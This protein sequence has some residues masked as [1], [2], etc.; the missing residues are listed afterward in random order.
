[1]TIRQPT[2]RYRQAMLLE[3]RM[4]FD[5]AAV[6]TAADV[7][8]TVAATDTA[9]GVDATPVQ[10]A[11]AITDSSDSFPAVDLFSGVTVTSDSSGQNL[12]ELVVTVN[13]SGANQ[14]LIIDGAEIKLQSGE[15]STD[16][17]YSYQVTVSGDAATIT[18]S[19]ESALEGGTPQATAA[20]IDS[21]AYQ[22]LDNTVESGAVTVTLKTLSDASDSAALDISSTV[23]IDSRV[24]VAPV[25][26]DD[27]ALEPAESFTIDDLGDNVT[28]VYAGGGDY[29]YAAGDGALSVF[30]VDDG[31]RLTLVGTS[32]VEGLGSV[33]DM[34]IGA[35]D[36]SLYLVNGGNGDVYAVS[37]AED[38]SLGAVSTVSAGDTTRNIALSSDGAYV[39]VTLQN[40]GMAVFARDGDSGALSLIQTVSEGDLGVSR[41]E[42]V[43]SANGYL[44]VIGDR[45]SFV[46][47]TDTLSVL[48]I[49]DDGTLTRIDSV[50]A[51]AVRSSSSTYLM[52]VSEDAAFLYL[53]SSA[54][55]SIQ[56]YRFSD[57]A[58]TLQSTLSLDGIS[59]IALSRDGGLLYAA[60]TGGAIG[61]YAVGGDGALTPVSSIAGGSA[62]DIAVSGDGLSVLV[63]GGGGVSRYSAAQT[64]DRGAY[65]TF[66]DG[67]TLADGN[68]DALNDGAGNYNG[69]GITVSANVAGG[70]FGFADGGGLTY[71]DG[72]ISLDG[73][74]IATLSVSDDGALTVKFTA[75]A[76]TAIANQVLQ[77]LTYANDGAAVGSYILLTVAASDGALASNSV[78]TTLRVNAVPQVN[79]DASTGYVLSAATSETDYSFTLFPGLFNDADGDSLIWSVSG[80]PQGL[81]F[82]AATRTI[83]GSATEAGDF[84]V[85][86]T[87]SDASGASA[88][89]DLDLTV[90]QIANR[91]P[92]VN[93]EVSSALA[94]ATENA[95]YSVTLDTSLFSDADSLYGDSLNWT[96]EGLPTGL[97]F[98]AATLTISGTAGAVG[99]YTVTVT[100]TDESGASASAE[101]T[102]RVI[103][104]DEA[105]NSAPVLDAPDSALAYTID[106]NLTGFNQYVYGLQLS[107]DDGT[108]IV[109]GN[110]SNS[111]AITPSGNSTL[112][113]YSRDTETGA[114]T[115]V[116]TFVQGAGDDGD[117]ANGIE[118]NGLDSATSSIYSADGQYVYLVGKDASGAYAI[119]VLSVNDDGTLS[120]TGLSAEVA[121]ASQIKQMVMSS[122][123]DSLYVVSASTL[124]AYRVEENG[125]LTLA[126]AYSDSY[127]TA[128]A[129]AVDSSGNVYVLGGSRLVVY[130]ANDDGSL[131]Y[132]TTGT[133]IGL[134]AT[135]RG[136]VV[137]DAGYIYVATGSGGTVVTLHYDSDSNAVTRVASVSAAQVWGL[138]LSADG[139]AL[140]VGYLTGAVYVYSV[141]DD[142]SL[143]RTDSLTNSGGRAFR[144]AISSDGSSI[145]VGGFY[146]GTGLGQISTGAVAVAYTEGGIVNPAA[147][148]TLS[149][150]DNDALNG[151][152]GNYNGAAFTL[153]RAGGANAADSYGFT[154]G[155]GLTLAD[156]IISLNGAAI[157]TF[158]S[159]DGALTVK[160][161]AD[162]ATAVANQVLQ[163]IAYSNGSA[164]PGGSITL[165][166]SVADQYRSGSL[167]LRLAVTEINDAPT[168][169][170]S[171][172]SVVYTSGGNAVKLF[173]DSAV[174]TVEEGQT[175]SSLT[176]TVS[177]LTDGESETL[178]VGGVSVA[179]T[180]GASAGGTITLNNEDGGTADYGYT[181]SVSVIDGV[182]TVTLSGSLPTEAADALIDSIAYAN[183]SDSP[184]IGER[185]ITLTSIQDNG[186]TD[187]GGVNTSELA[188]ASTVAVALTNAA[189][190]VSATP[191]VA[192]YVENA[193]AA[194]LF[195][196][197]VL[198]TGEAGQAIS[199]IVLTVSG[200][201]DGASEALVI[202]GTAVSLTADAAGETANGYS[203]SVTL[204]GTT[205]T[206]TISGSDGIAVQDATAL[207]AGLGYANQSDDPTAG[208]RTVT[209]AAVQDDGGTANG[210]S[211]SVTP[212]IAASVA[213]VAVN[214]APLVS[215]TPA[216]AIYSTSGSSAG[217][218]SDVSLSTVENDQTLSAIT[219]TVAG[220]ADGDSET[221]TVAGSRIA[222]VDGSGTL[223]NGYAYT[224]TLDGDTAVVT[225]ASDAGIAA[226]AA[227]ALIEQSS[228][229]NL[230]NTQTAGVRTF[231]LS[232]Q[233]SGGRDNGGSDTALLE[234]AAA[235]E[236]V[237]NSAPEF[238][239]G[240][241]YTNL[242]VA[243]SLTAVSGLNDITASALTAGGDYLYVAGSDG[244]IAIFSRNTATGEL[245]LL[246]T[247]DSGVSSVSLIEVSEDGGTLYLLG[248]GGD[249]ITIFSR[250]GGD[251][252]LTQV[253][254]LT[255]ENVVDLTISAD[256][257]ALYVVDGNYS[258]LLV[259]T[260][261]AESGQYALRQSISAATG[262][263][264]YLFTAIGVE[265][266]GDYVYVATDPAAET[267]ANTL[268][269]YQRAADGTLSAV[270]WLRDGAAAGESAI[271]MSGPVDIAVSRD[272][273]T[274]YVA[275]EDGVAVFGFDAA[276]GTL[277]YDGALG[278]LSGVTAVALSGDDGTLYVTS[279][280][281]SISRY[282]SDGSLTL[283]ET[284][285]SSSTAALAGARSV[286]TG[287][288][289]AVVVI[290]SGGVVSLKDGLTAITVDY[291]EQETIRPLNAITL[292]DADYDALADGAGNYN[293]AVITLA[294][295]GGASGDDG[296]SFVD[297][298]GLTLADGTIYLDGA[299]I[300]AFADVEGTL[301]LT[302]T[303]DVT[304]ASANR[305]LQQIGYSNASDDPGANLSLVLRVT[306]AYGAGAGVTLSLNVTEVNDAPL[307]TTT[308]ADAGYVEGGEAA[309][310][311]S[312]TAV[313]TVEAGQRVNALTL[314]V[315]GLSDGAGETLTID[316]T[317]IALIAGSGTTAGGYAYSVSLSDGVATVAIAGEAGISAAAAAALVDGIAY[318]NVSDDP[319]VGTR[320]I[321]LSA[322]QD[323]GG[324]ADGGV[325]ATTLAVTAAVTVTAVNDAPTL[326]V[327][328]INANYAA[329]DDALPLFNGAEVAAVE[330]GQSIAALTVTV[331]GVADNAERLI[332][333]GASVTLTDG[334]VTTASGLTVTV[335]L[336]NGTATLV[337]TRAD[338]LSS[339]G[340]AALI[341]GLAYANDSAV[342]TA[343]ER[344]I[345][346][347]AVQDDG[348]TANGGA[349]TAVLN[350]AATVNIVNSAPQATDAEAELPA[351]TQAAAY[352]ATL[353]GDLF[354]DV[355]GDALS[356]RVDGLPEG[357]V[358]DA[359]T[360][361]IS[362]RTLAVGSFELTITVS[363]GQ[364]GTA[365]RS[366]TLTV[367]KQ[368]VSPVFL[369]ASNASDM[370]ERLS[371]QEEKRREEAQNAS[372]RPTAPPATVQ[373]GDSLAREHYPL[374]NGA[375]D[376]A[377]TPWLLNP[378]LA[379]LMP[380]LEKVDF[381]PQERAAAGAPARENHQPDPQAVRTDIPAG[382]AAFS[383]QLQQDRA[384]YDD[385]LSAL[386][387]LTANG[388]SP[389]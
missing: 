78:V 334:A 7:A 354:S 328:P 365:S 183:A 77:Q 85:T 158:A 367:D 243:A 299:A 380:P 28:V 159:A 195:S 278:D 189:P 307:L 283:V 314:S 56:V 54:D 46:A 96:V 251:G 258:G 235:I 30:A 369:P 84:T 38:G 143:T 237:N 23:T 228:Y 133:G 125:A 261:D 271:N 51:S 103:T 106:G 225:I 308:S 62:S 280:D 165:T 109:L 188:I 214:D 55:N 374:A 377:A 9:P 90:E 285:S 12:T 339:A 13:R 257:S 340:A 130:S 86:V 140:Y 114:L 268:I 129:V 153:A 255:T 229:A 57:G 104:L 10:A 155:N 187:N 141:N 52:A 211:D 6:T 202:D 11:V 203:Y 254:S 345:T 14:A 226:D 132:A 363:D 76:A 192:T 173:D 292:S 172:G 24:N 219:F 117:N 288:H 68:F 36:R 149:D 275:S 175:V 317:A 64:L 161:T 282:K 48:K 170:T 326:S 293:G 49:N 266:V 19:I 270:A 346:L 16:G 43:V 360:R 168:L 217:L 131:T 353:A 220:L 309:G 245:V 113:V 335:T 344:I 295:D 356:W 274:I 311:F 126:G 40:N 191:A 169:Q 180:D 221:L 361:T 87:V 201:S 231:A 184:T 118:I 366:L 20:L 227:A 368:P 63:A 281:G 291:H 33:A 302:F 136:I 2:P 359:D 349:D 244:G 294:R 319:T 265:T 200:L 216:D 333:D 111:H 264:P 102:L 157:G 329:G 312:G 4:M 69:A 213:V 79:T 238:S 94:N 256:G 1:M 323:N 301:T 355:N 137:S 21:I 75:D 318:A 277:S 25:L 99:D 34:A 347:T 249:S 60:T 190:A 372:L 145:Y 358:F 259:Y 98:D 146:N 72:V 147:S 371:E 210:G 41:A 101:L 215:A 224:V 80:L 81:T 128:S 324:T 320:G 138:S 151:G 269:V 336:D 127:G 154:D 234:S 332:V 304:T 388:A 209:L 232:V 196:D 248:A 122:D 325:D 350:I 178:T 171:G 382:K 342:V 112:Y 176:L 152:A 29:A 362:G 316:G 376:Y 123:G 272:G 379:E 61:V 124:Y 3:P 166:L 253:Q 267:V 239:A 186:G 276:G 193:D 105:N 142:G 65:A 331:S 287:A 107:A 44:F 197:V 338:G 88:S 162:V 58:L 230:S 73:A 205:A 273:G 381:S 100:A 182:A 385:L 97:T 32:A 95:G 357:L 240:A 35:D 148:V 150:A 378:A 306:D 250:D 42:T 164:D 337:I 262:S 181:L 386:R 134:S 389:E 241:D 207:I 179:L 298:N 364:G 135:S 174:S 296:Y 310:L 242:E 27:G 17:G 71:A 218:F 139:T 375:L 373:D 185:I 246:Q 18:V 83:S 22:P 321:T 236:V 47:Y 223:D 384:A 8:A 120:A 59:G 26:S 89:L 167:D 67:I 108:L 352:R 222:L 370:M 284:L 70:S 208:A 39:Y 315:S 119:T 177:G 45:S 74:A 305:V 198:S 327:A 330:A 15:G 163:Q 50:T 351:A 290:G 92:Q 31:G 322:I 160:F 110:S 115:L 252:S 387:Q 303:A 53:G 260:L 121:D 82:D 199:N 66:A 37:L 233:D 348:G 91:A 204:D 286:V 343:G 383:A 300:A 297:G 279:S 93:E 156:G 212:S 341:D 313:S 116:Q 194:T 5:A 289:G 247:L 144:Y 263:E 206:V